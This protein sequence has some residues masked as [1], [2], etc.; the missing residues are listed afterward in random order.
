M[1]WSV[2]G[3]PVCLLV[4]AYATG[5]SLDRYPTVGLII[6]ITL[7]VVVMYTGFRALP[8]SGDG[9]LLRRVLVA[10]CY[11]GAMCF[12]WPVAFFFGLILY[13]GLSV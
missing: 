12:I 11:C 6:G 2:I 8:W 1:G 5:S 10:V 3:V 4:I 7:S 13:G 9:S